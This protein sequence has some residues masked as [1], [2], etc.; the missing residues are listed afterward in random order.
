MFLGISCIPNYGNFWKVHSGMS[1]IL[2]FT[3]NCKK[4]ICKELSYFSDFGKGICQI[5]IRKCDINCDIANDNP[6]EIY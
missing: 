3:K 6:V 4:K 2:D 1:L 5:P